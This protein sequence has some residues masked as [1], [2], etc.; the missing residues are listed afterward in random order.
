[1]QRKKFFLALWLAVLSVT[2]LALSGCGAS[3]DAATAMAAI[4]SLP[5]RVPDAF[6]Y[7]AESTARNNMLT[8][9]SDN[10]TTLIVACTDTNEDF[11]EAARKQ[12]ITAATLT[13]SYKESGLDVSIDQLNKQSTADKLL[14]TYTVHL[15][16]LSGN[17]VTHKY[18]RITKTRALDL[19][20][21]GDAENSDAI[22]A[23]YRAVVAAIEAVEA[24][25]EKEPLKTK[26]ELKL[27]GIDSGI[28]SGS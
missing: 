4:E 6:S 9:V 21:G 14:Y 25:T 19:S 27:T 23:D 22:D 26:S 1:M 20:C 8:F 13:A 18:I 15:P 7:S 2:G 12:T 17:T 24:A 3:N 10:Q 28:V 16:S 5:F 11:L